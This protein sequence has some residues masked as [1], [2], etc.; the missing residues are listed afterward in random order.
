MMS[1]GNCG[2]NERMHLETLPK[3]GSR[4]GVMDTS[5][6]TDMKI[7]ITRKAEETRVA[8]VTSQEELRKEGRNVSSYDAETGRCELLNR[9]LC[10]AGLRMS[11]VVSFELDT[12]RELRISSIPGIGQQ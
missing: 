5:Q 11:D 10:M 7:D 9:D 12:L 3:D 4:M 1:Y 8:G 6:R 2:A